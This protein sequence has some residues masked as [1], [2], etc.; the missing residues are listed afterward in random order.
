[1]LRTETSRWQGGRKF[2]RPRNRSAFSVRRS[3]FGGAVFEG[4]A[5]AVARGSRLRPPLK[6]A[7]ETR[8]FIEPGEHL[9][10]FQKVKRNDSLS[11]LL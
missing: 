4:H 6:D 7:S 11:S 2:E 9:T 1:M 8:E 3:A 5:E 10:L